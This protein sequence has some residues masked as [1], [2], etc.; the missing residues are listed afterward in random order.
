VGRPRRPTRDPTRPPSPPPHPLPAQIEQLVSL[1]APDVVLVELCKDRLGLLLPPKAG[2]GRGP[3]LWHAAATRLAGVP[4]DPGWPAPDALLACARTAPGAPVSTA[5]IE[6]DCVRLQATGLFRAVRPA[7]TIPS[8]TAAPAYVPGRDGALVPAMPLGAVTFSATP[9][10][11][12][13]VTRGGWRA[14]TGLAAAGGSVD[15]AAADAAVAALVAAADAA[16][17][18]GRP[19]ATAGALAGAAAGL[20][21]LVAGVPDAAVSYTGLE[22]GRLEVV[23]TLGDP[24]RPG[25]LTGLEASAVG[26]VGPGIEPFVPYRGPLPITK[27]MRVD[28]MAN[29]LEVENESVD[30]VSPVGG[31]GGAAAAR[32]FARRWPPPPPL[33]AAKAEGD[34]EE[35]TEEEAGKG[36]T[37][38]PSAVDDDDDDPPSRLNDVLNLLAR[39]L[40]KSY[41]RYQSAAGDKLGVADGAAWRAALAAAHAA[42]SAA[43]VVADSPANAVARR[44]AAR[45][46]AAVPLAVAA[47]V[48]VAVAATAALD[49]GA[50]P[51]AA[52]PAVRAAAAL[53]IA[54]TV[55]PFVGPYV[56]VSRFAAKAP[57]E[58]EALV[59][60]S[61]PLATATAA[62]YWGE[63]ALLGWP[64]AAGPLIDDRDA[65]MAATAFAAAG[66]SGLAPAYARD[67]DP[68][69]R[70]VW[71]FAA[72]AGGGVRRATPRHAGEGEYEPPAAPRAI[73]AIVGTAHVPGMRR[74][75]ARLERGEA[76]ATELA[77]AAARGLAA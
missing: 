54:A 60:P 75:W 70:A 42:G 57:E 53:A 10:E 3:T 21:A 40:T 61:E 34:E 33:P 4:T 67:V 16:A 25:P 59:S 51:E 7:T 45:V 32:A 73:V 2:A 47:A 43:V 63:D 62:R 56:E 31:G 69:G 49:S 46:A 14:D 22:T 28:N 52:A 44:M 20:A 17:A 41:A 30:D 19:G 77:D 76:D 66:G 9:R 24:A 13:P 35:A 8:P 6:A 72:P 5:D 36:D 68:A 71:R 23:F 26:G 29:V 48:G 1:V 50:V 55:W 11:L 38:T 74:V 12:P 27:T 65:F 37:D 58:L 15:T 39:T 18:S 64:G